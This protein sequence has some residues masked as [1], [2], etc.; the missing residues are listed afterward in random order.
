MLIDLWAK[1]TTPGAIY[2]DVTWCGYVGENPPAKYQEIFKTVCDARDAAL[3]LV[4]SRFAAGEVCYGWEVDDACREVVIN[5]GYG[6]YFVHRTGHSIGVNVHGNGANI[7]NFETKDERLLVPGVCFSVEP[8]IYLEGDMAVRTEINICILPNG[9][10]KVFGDIQ[11]SL[12]L[13]V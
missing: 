9:E 5:A 10:V 2:Y 1:K 7:D 8:G 13:A 11:D 6:D 4:K 3:N 12:I